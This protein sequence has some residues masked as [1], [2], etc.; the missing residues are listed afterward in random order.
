MVAETRTAVVEF[1]DIHRG[2]TS[3]AE[4]SAFELLDVGSVGAGGLHDRLAWFLSWTF[5]PPA[6]AL[7]VCSKLCTNKAF[8]TTTVLLNN[9]VAGDQSHYV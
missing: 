1:G 8:K 2:D 7:G 3:Q 9:W 6:Q 4:L 5:S